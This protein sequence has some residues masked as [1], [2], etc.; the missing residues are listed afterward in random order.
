MVKRVVFGDVAND[1]VK[2]LTDMNSREA[3]MLIVL[4]LSVLALGVY[5]DPLVD[6]LEPTLNNLLTHITQTKL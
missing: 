5:P 1:N 2:S 4:A 3:F 6:M